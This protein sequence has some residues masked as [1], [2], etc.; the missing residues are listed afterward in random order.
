MRRNLPPPLERLLLE[1]AYAREIVLHG[2]VTLLQVLDR[3]D[4][5]QVVTQLAG[6]LVVGV[7]HGVV[8]GTLQRL[9][10]LRVEVVAHVVAERPDDGHVGV[11][12]LQAEEVLAAYPARLVVVLARQRVLEE[13]HWPPVDVVDMHVGPLLAQQCRMGHGAAPAE[14]VHEAVALRQQRDDALGQLV[15]RAHIGQSVFH[16]GVSFRSCSLF[17]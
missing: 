7:E 3:V 17:E 14:Q 9:D 11:G 4:E 8:D 13:L 1:V 16:V 15:L 6:G 12:V 5:R 2:E 10:V